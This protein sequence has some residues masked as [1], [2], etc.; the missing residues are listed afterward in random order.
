MQ[1][2]NCNNEFE[3]N[4]CNNCGQK[5]D[6]HRLTIKHA[7][8]DFF[9]SFVHVDTGLLYLIMQM[10][11]R[12]GE[13]VKEYLAGK[14][15]SYFNPT[16]YLIL[17]VAAATFLSINFTLMGDTAGT[18]TPEQLKQLP[19]MQQIFLQFNKFIYKYFNIILF[20]S[21]PLMALFTRLFYRSSG[22]NYAE[23]L[24]LMCFL[25]GQRTL[26]YICLAPFLYF[27]RSYW[28]VFIGIYYLGW[29]IY[30]GWTFTQ[31]FKGKKS[32]IIFKYIVIILI[33]LPLTQ[34]LSWGVFLLFFY[35]PL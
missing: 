31:F 11:K 29:I 27:F 6:T 13:V 9:H 25:G 17:T 10:A 12:P 19:E 15:R 1:C 22:Y 26:F 8:H 30:Y 5:A 7:L 23:N 20:L 24:T 4:F 18:I 14:R 35:K 2:K 33:F 28:F 21:V 32:S 16:Q 34:A 3:G